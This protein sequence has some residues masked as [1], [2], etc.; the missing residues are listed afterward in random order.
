MGAGAQ[1]SGKAAALPVLPPPR[2]LNDDIKG[3]KMTSKHTKGLV[4]TEKEGL[5]RTNKDRKGLVRTQK[6]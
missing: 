2:T 4:R 1:K 6:D 5:G 3:R